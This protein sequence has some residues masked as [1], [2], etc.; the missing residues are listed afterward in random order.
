[1]GNTSDRV[2][3]DRHGSKAHRSDSGGSHKDPEPSSKMVDSTDDP[4]IFNT[5]G[6]ESKVQYS[7]SPLKW[8]LLYNGIPCPQK[9]HF[10]FQLSSLKK[11]FRFKAC[12]SLVLL[13]PLS[14]LHCTNSNQR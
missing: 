14:L 6:L 11:G 1:M 2:S 3:A 8:H 7:R 9:I 5:H 12:N 13:S 10:I 4:N